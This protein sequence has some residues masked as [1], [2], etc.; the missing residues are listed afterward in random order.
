MKHPAA[1]FTE[2]ELQEILNIS[3]LLLMQC[4]KNQ[5]PSLSEF[6]NDR[7]QTVQGIILKARKT[8]QQ[9]QKLHN[10]C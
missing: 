9:F 10:R 3:N 4:I 6:G 8:Q 1:L 5:D 2:Q 7:K